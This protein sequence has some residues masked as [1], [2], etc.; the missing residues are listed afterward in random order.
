MEHSKPANTAQ[1]IFRAVTIWAR[2]HLV[3]QSKTAHY[4]YPVHAHPTCSS[5]NV[6]VSHGTMTMPRVVEASSF[7]GLGAGRGISKY[8]AGLPDRK[9]LASRSEL[10]G[11]SSSTV[12]LLCLSFLRILFNSGYL[13]ECR[14]MQALVSCTFQL[15]PL[16]TYNG[17]FSLPQHWLPLF[18]ILVASFASLWSITSSS[19]LTFSLLHSATKLFHLCTPSL[20]PRSR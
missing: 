13:L 6:E 8:L 15:S 10:L 1:L 17:P 9:P 7:D 14:E 16:V 11:N 5:S 3:R 19:S 20:C 18:T 12:Y 2:P 4:Q